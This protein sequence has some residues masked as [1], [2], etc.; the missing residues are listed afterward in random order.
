MF[1]ELWIK[2]ACIW[3][4][5]VD[6]RLGVFHQLFSRVSLGPWKWLTKWLVHKIMW[7]S[8]SSLSTKCHYQRAPSKTVFSRA[9]SFQ[10]RHWRKVH[11]A[12]NKISLHFQ[13]DCWSKARCL[14]PT[15]QFKFSTYLYYVSGELGCNLAI[16][17]TASEFTPYV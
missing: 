10:L 5:F 7:Q 3:K 1:F 17:V 9:M 4:L 15:V 11:S 13:T 14:S 16:A 8:S 6:H 2:L 12:L